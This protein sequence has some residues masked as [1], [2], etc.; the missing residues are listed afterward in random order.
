M[1]FCQTDDLLPPARTMM[2]TPSSAASSTTD[3]RTS[4]AISA[5]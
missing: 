2:E 4:G 5:L 1:G 3:A